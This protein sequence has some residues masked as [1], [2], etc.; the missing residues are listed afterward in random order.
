MFGNMGGP[1]TFTSGY[2][3]GGCVTV[4]CV[5]V[6]ARWRALALACLV[7]VPCPCACSVPVLR[8]A[9]LRVG[10]SATRTHGWLSV[11]ACAENGLGQRHCCAR[12]R[13]GL[14]ATV[15]T[16]SCPPCARALSGDALHAA[17]VLTRPVR[18]A[19][20]N[21]SLSSSNFSSNSVKV[22]S[23]PPRP[24]CA[25][26][27]RVSRS[28]LILLALQPRGMCTS[29]TAH[30]SALAPVNA[31]PPAGADGHGHDDHERIL[32]SPL[33]HA[34]RS[35]VHHLHAHSHGTHTKQRAHPR[36]L[37]II[38]LKQLKALASPP[39]SWPPPPPKTADL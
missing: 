3:G 20:R 22:D 30:R 1:P 26:R 21:S 2:Q 18:A 8:C 6:R 14:H 19:C 27:A 24:P 11:A 36:V 39:P 5:W 34:Q 17:S 10:A 38:G 23:P 4:S 29:S 9:V 28:V 16:R 33:H 13:R 37:Q 31:C 35:L 7:P 15:Q 25:Q 32:S 12:S